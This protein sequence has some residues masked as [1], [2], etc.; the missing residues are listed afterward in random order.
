MFARFRDTAEALAATT[1][2]A[3][4]KLGESLEKFL[5]DI[6]KKGLK[7][8]LAVMDAKVGNIIMEKLTSSC[9]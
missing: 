4:S 5:K 3:E 7:E 8:Q 1:A 9:T 2:L 6:V